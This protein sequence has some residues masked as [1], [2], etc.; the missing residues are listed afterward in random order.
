M[1]GQVHENGL[2][3]KEVLLVVGQVSENGLPAKEVL[4]MDG[5]DS[6]DSLPA[7][8]VLLMVGQVPQDFPPLFVG[9]SPLLCS[10]QQSEEIQECGVP[11]E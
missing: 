10:V 8:E 11:A 5:H 6:K 1:V 7:K 9:T 4:L 3:A 2:P